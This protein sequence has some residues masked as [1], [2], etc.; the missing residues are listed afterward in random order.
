M[1]KD[2]TMIFAFFRNL[3]KFDFGKYII[4]IH[5]LVTKKFD[6]IKYNKY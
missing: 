3:L 4:K 2:I 5:I 6:N 1:D